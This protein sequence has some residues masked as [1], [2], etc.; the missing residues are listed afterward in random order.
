[1]KGNSEEARSI[2]SRLDLYK[3][4]VYEV[5]KRL[6]MNEIKINFENFRNEYQGKKSRVRLLIPIF[7]EHNRKIK[8]L[9][10][11]ECTRYL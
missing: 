11:Q 2:N 7:E 8:E 3:A 5:E 6:F 1:M 10:G 4:N 9:V